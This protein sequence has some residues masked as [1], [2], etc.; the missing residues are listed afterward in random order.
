MRKVLALTIIL[1]GTALLTPQVGLP[2]DEDC[3][4]ANCAY[5]DDYVEICSGGM[6]ARICTVYQCSGGTQ[7]CCTECE[8]P[9]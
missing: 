5:V 7:T 2:T 9:N 1:L 8:G 3:P 4:L 6:G